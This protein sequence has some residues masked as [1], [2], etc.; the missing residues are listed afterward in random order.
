[1]TGVEDSDDTDYSLYPDHGVA[2]S[3]SRKR[4]RSPQATTTDGGEGDNGSTGHGTG[5]HRS[6][7]G[8]DAK[9]R[10]RHSS[11][12]VE[13]DGNNAGGSGGSVSAADSASESEVE[14][15]D[16]QLNPE[17]FRSQTNDGLLE[18]LDATFRHFM[19]VCGTQG[20]DAE[21]EPEEG[22]DASVRVEE[23]DHI[24]D[25]LLVLKEKNFRDM[26]NVLELPS[27]TT[28]EKVEENKTIMLDSLRELHRELARRGLANDND[29]EGKRVH[30]KVIQMVEVIRT[31][32]SGV[33]ST[34]R[35]EALRKGENVYSVPVSKEGV[36][37]PE[38]GPP[39]D[40][41]LKSMAA[42]LVM[43]KQI[44]H[45][46]N[47]RRVQDSDHYYVQ[48]LNKVGKPTHYWKRG[49]TLV[50]LVN[51]ICSAETNFEMWNLLV[52]ISS[53][54]NRTVDTIASRLRDNEDSTFPRL[55]PLEKQRRWH[56][57]ENGVLDVMTDTFYLYGD[58]AL[59]DDVVSI[60]YHPYA[61][62]L[63]LFSST[64]YQSNPMS[65][66]TPNIDRLW[67]LQGLTEE[68]AMWLLGLGPGR[69]LYELLTFDTWACALTII[70]GPGTG[71]TSFVNAVCDIF[72][73]NLIRILNTKSEERFA[74]ANLV[75]GAIWTCPELRKRGWNLAEDYLLRMLEGAENFTI[76]K[77]NVTAYQID[78]WTMP[79][80]FAGNHL[81]QEWPEAVL[82]RI[83]IFRFDKQPNEAEQ[84][85]EL[86]Q[87]IREERPYYMVKGM[88]I[89]HQLVA[90]YKHKDIH[91]YLPERLRA[92]LNS[93][94][95]S[96]VPV[97][98]MLRETV[99]DALIVEPEGIISKNDFSAV[100]RL[101]CENANLR[102][103]SLPEFHDFHR[104]LEKEGF[105]LVDHRKHPNMNPPRGIY[106][107]GLRRR[108]ESDAGAEDQ[109]IPGLDAS[110]S[111]VGGSPRGAPGI[112]GSGA[113]A[114]AAGPSRNASRQKGMP[115]SDAG[116]A[117]GLGYD[118]DDVFASLQGVP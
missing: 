97:V 32:F 118:D 112:G 58:D 62:D 49:G 110:H 109:A 115:T 53:S 37:F 84:H 63:E 48:Q 15:P 38:T 50:Q 92:N 27:D 59:T 93:F 60:G 14:Q 67:K 65:I 117:S 47:Y 41:Q 7:A 11:D 77:K 31:A 33:K 81:P 108:R 52:S 5:E 6:T 1:M 74:L 64:E 76:Q 56:S 88:R 12:E 55:P 13:E 98:R 22:E 2:S 86:T 51:T 94:Q 43:V 19:A 57:F 106:I 25:H 99:G 73:R 39:E 18:L 78:R 61:M 20:E 10:R 104:I 105:R 101:W 54:V 85:Q 26:Y 4:G 16:L 87:Y 8:D 9:R 100:Y 116:S 69:S 21:E 30:R 107:H 34:M 17:T 44:V 113:G 36:M 102:H 45:D 82:R 46:L 42:L 80:I 72:P 111:N 23:Q 28:V 68:E 91:F 96:I 95:E 35:F 71:K 29:E 40:V 79:A 114:A 90:K 70:G 75:G 83:I 66:P 103:A 3:P 89:Y 24:P